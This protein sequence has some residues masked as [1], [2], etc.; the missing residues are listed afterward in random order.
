MIVEYWLASRFGCAW[1]AVRPGLRA[2]LGDMPHTCDAIAGRE[3]VSAALTLRAQEFAL[4]VWARFAVVTLIPG[5]AVFGVAAA[6]RPGP[7]VRIAAAVVLAVAVVLMMDGLAQMWLLRYR[8]DRT[9]RYLREIGQEASN[10]TL[11]V[12]EAG[13]PHRYDF[14]V[15][16]SVTLLAFVVLLYAGAHAR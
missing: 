6:I 8:A 10:E 16:L 7:G 9:R 5:F 1:L 13:H 2:R 12:H 11:P 14:W 3:Q 15:V 4:R